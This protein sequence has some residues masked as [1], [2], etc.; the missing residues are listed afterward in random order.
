[1][2]V[3]QLIVRI[4]LAWSANPCSVRGKTPISSH[5]F[6]IL[7]LYFFCGFT[8]YP[9]LN[10]NLFYCL[11]PF[12]SLLYLIRCLMTTCWDWIRYP[13]HAGLDTFTTSGSTLTLLFLTPY[14]TFH[15][16]WSCVLW[17]PPTSVFIE[18]SSL[19]RLPTKAEEFFLT[20]IQTIPRRTPS[21]CFKNSRILLFLLLLLL[22][23]LFLYF[24]STI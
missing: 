13:T 10:Y 23:L 17:F 20:M 22:L 14:V 18:T 6:F 3:S 12:Y 19:E 11:F 1:M 2:S 5:F 7:C 21:W 15:S 4:C 24:Q 8:P 9:A 16:I